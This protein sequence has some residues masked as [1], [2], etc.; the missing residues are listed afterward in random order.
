M[1]DYHLGAEEAPWLYLKHSSKDNK[2]N[3]DWDKT[4]RLVNQ[5]KNWDCPD[6]GS[7]VVKKNTEEGAGNRGKLL[8]LDIQ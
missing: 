4:G 5:R 7:A 6:Q 3:K 1:N 2:G 8:S